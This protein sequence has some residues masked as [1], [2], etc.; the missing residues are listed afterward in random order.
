M[1]ITDL[2]DY[3]SI[4]KL[5]SALHHLDACQHGAA[6][7]IGAGF[8]RSAAQH[9]GGEK[10][11]PL[12]D[13]FTKKLLAELNPGETNLSFSDPL[14][15]AEEYRAYFGQAALNDRIRFEIDND[16][17]RTGDLYR[18]LLELP[19]SEVMTTNWDTLLERAAGDIHGP[20]YTPVYKTSDLTWAS[21][22]RIVKLHGTIGVTESF[23]AAQ[24]DY[25]TYPERFAPLVNFAR[26]VFI[27]NELCLL[28]F[29]G[30]DPNFLHWTGWVRDHLAEHARKIYL[31][32]AL[33]LSAARRKHLE[34]INI[35]PIDLWDAVSHI[36][37]CDLRHRTAAE[38]F[39]KSMLDERKSKMAPH[40]W[41]PQSLHPE[42]ITAAEYSKCLEDHK[43]AAS[44]LKEQ[45]GILKGDRESYPGWLICPPGLRWKVASQLSHPWPNAGSIDALSPAERTQL[46]YEISWRQSKAFEIVSPW[47]ADKLFEIALSDT[48]IGI[49]KVQ[50]MEI[51]LALLKNSRWLD[52]NNESADLDIQEY[53]GSLTELLENNSQYLPDCSAEI[54]YHRALVARDVLDYASIELFAENIAGADPV[55]KLRKAALQMELGSFA[56]S[57]RLIADAYRELQE[58]FRYD[59]SSIPILSRMAW[60]H[61]LLKAATQFRTDE[62]IK[63]L[64]TIVKDLHCDPWTW[65][66]EIQRE[67]SKQQEN[68]IKS[69]TSIE[70]L[71][72]QG[73]YRDN[74]TQQSFSNEPNAFMLLDGITRDVGVPLHSGDV[75]MKVNLLAGSGEK[76]ILAGGVGDDLRDFSM[77]VR[78][79]SSESSPSIKN[80]LTR[81]GVARA[82]Q[83]AVDITITRL[84]KAIDFWRTKRSHGTTDQQG[85][86]LSVLRVLIE[87]LAR[88]VVR[89]TSVKAKEIFRLA[90]SLGQQ[91]NL[92]H[93]WLFDVLNSLLTNAIDS[94]P[95]SEQG[96]LLIDALDFPL[97]NEV[98]DNA[99]PFWP[100]PV[101]HYPNSRDTYPNQLK[102]I[103]ELI[104]FAKP[105]TPSSSAAL[106]RL[107]PLCKKDGFLTSADYEKLTRVLW[108]ES[109]NYR[110]IPHVPNLF[111]HAFLLLPAPNIEK[112][113]V[114]IH[115]HLYNHS[116]EVLTDTRKELRSFPSSE[117]HDAIIIYEG[118]A[119]AAAS[120]PTSLL[121]TPEQAL[122]IFD[123][124]VAWRPIKSYADTLGL[125]NG[126][127]KRLANS[128]GKALSYAIAPALRITDINKDRFEKLNLFIK[129]VDNSASAIPALVYFVTIDE[130]I[131][132]SVEITIRKSMQSSTASDVGVSA[133]SIYK[134]MELSEA[135]SLPQFN[136][137]IARLVAIIELGRSVGLHHL[138]WVAD[139]L[140]RKERL[141]GDEIKILTESIADIFTANQYSNINPTSQ[142]AIS[143]SSVREGCVKLANTLISEHL[144]SSALKGLLDEAQ[145]DP[146]PEVRYALDSLNLT[147]RNLA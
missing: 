81:I 34:S 105:N 21:S 99:F 57:R 110:D 135:S 5:A 142:E 7:M 124:L 35:A 49:T 86:A 93:I 28:G 36:E 92:Q 77:T 129:D 125:Q 1:L 143:A 23:I 122:S 27:E 61:F 126:E 11:M 18:S 62:A 40:E 96:E 84:L 102:R 80:F 134:W 8:S 111:P 55:W 104:E 97:Q 19:W 72:Q 106:L 85:H 16:A 82:S 132:D 53:I 90:V 140:I 131:A 46:L 38:L 30:D 83:D 136:R 121:P 103:G 32:G 71:F 101:I 114:L 65:I 45:L 33:N 25:R 52:A 76:L 6:I 15:I 88:L 146:L 4:K 13:S 98:T 91:R 60:A 50:R 138:L 117:I 139:E 2:S 95:K 14:R 17:W 51:A 10:K 31:V 115:N 42:Q 26:Q 87:V 89:T 123:R 54:A 108:G 9:V 66:E 69:Q 119:N 56:E 116:D 41:S 79:A 47:L 68:H 112:V 44:V 118:V 127:R 75:F 133:S 37:D 107:L 109:P 141:S 144:G 128:T 113:K 70:P 22:P 145:K 3:P 120:W 94:V 74:S 67:S 58:R 39:L 20:Y 147:I 48:T 137:L 100:N 12:W 29:S 73:H 64:P 63:A 59:Q 24:E 78:A 130:S 43:Y